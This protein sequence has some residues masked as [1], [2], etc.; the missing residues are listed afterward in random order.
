M[1]LR[2]VE[3]PSEPAIMHH[4]IPFQKQFLF[5][6]SA[7]NF[8]RSFASDV[9]DENPRQEAIKRR[10]A[11]QRFIICS[12]PPSRLNWS[13]FYDTPASAQL[14]LIEWCN[15]CWNRRLSRVD[16]R[17]KYIL[18]ITS[19]VKYSPESNWGLKTRRLCS[20]TRSIIITCH[21]LAPKRLPMIPIQ[22]LRGFA[23]G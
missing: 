20:F 19:P 17:K 9:A 8:Q 3:P 16:K 22:P 11:C 6:L 23:H 12:L 7:I 4:L 21:K 10:A 2:F 1:K 13:T 14:V 15:M 5:I 18:S